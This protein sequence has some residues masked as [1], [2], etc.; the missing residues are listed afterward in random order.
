[1]SLPPLPPIRPVR[2][3]VDCDAARTAI[4]DVFAHD[5]ARFAVI[6]KL[7][8]RM[9]VGRLVVDP[10]ADQ[11]KAARDVALLLAIRRCS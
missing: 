6:C 2:F 9:D 3:D 4:A 5:E 11:R 7:N 10:P 1:M 8:L